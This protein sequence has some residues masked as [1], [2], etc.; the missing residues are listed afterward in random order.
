MPHLKHFDNLNTVRFITFSCYRRQ[1]LLVVPNVIQMFLSAVAEARN[2][3]CFRLLGYAIMP[4]HVHLVIHPPDGILVGPM[5]G[6]IKSLSGRDIIAKSFIQLP[7]NC[8]V[9]RNGK[10]RWAFWQPRCYDHNCRTPEIV[11]EKINYCHNNP[12]KRGLVSEPGD[13]RWSS[14]NWYIGK[15]DVPIE[16]DEFDGVQTD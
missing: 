5:I 14:Y 11:L 8:R 2:K 3:H 10:E 12:V 15:R 7:V 16:I 4:E 6:E 13:W 1:Q 9:N